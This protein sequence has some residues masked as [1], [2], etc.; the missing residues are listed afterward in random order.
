MVDHIAETTRLAA[1]PHRAASESGNGRQLL[2]RSRAQL[3]YANAAYAYVKMRYPPVHEHATSK[4]AVHV[5]MYA[6][7]A[8]RRRSSRI[9][10]HNARAITPHKVGG[11]EGNKRGIRRKVV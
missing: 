9:P 2:L 5:E 7:S 10:P 1:S 11:K 8:R 6:G 4:C 3:Q